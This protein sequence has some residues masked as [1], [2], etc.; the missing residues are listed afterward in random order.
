MSTHVARM[1]LLSLFGIVILA[2]SLDAGEPAPALKKTFDK[3]LD[4]IKNNDR[5][6]FVAEGNEEVK[7]GMTPEVMET[8]HKHL[9]TRIKA[10]FEAK[11]LCQLK[12]GGHEVHLWKLSFKDAGDD[13]VIRLARKDGK[14][15]GFFLQ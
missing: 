8:L 3:M 9:G 10:G 4:A 7:K 5:D 6:A 1:G 2:L 11:Y 15:A 14:V 13:V 12:Q